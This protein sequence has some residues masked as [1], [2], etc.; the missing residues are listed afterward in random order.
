[1]DGDTMRVKAKCWIKH[2]DPLYRAGDIFTVTDEAL[3][4]LKGCVEVL[5]SEQHESDEN[6]HQNQT[7]ATEAKPKRGRRTKS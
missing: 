7:A 1:M 5:D 2:G 3:D 6:D 4:A